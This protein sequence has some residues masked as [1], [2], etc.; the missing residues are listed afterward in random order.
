MSEEKAGPAKNLVLVNL[1]LIALKGFVV[2][3][4]GSLAVA[5]SLFDTCFDLLGAGFA[6]LGMKD[7]AKPADPEHP[8]G[9]GKIEHF[10]SLAQIALITFTAFVIIFEAVKRLV[11]PVMLSIG[12]FDIAIMFFTI[13][14]DVL[15]ARY[16][17]KQSH[18]LGS[19]ALAAAAAN[20]KS[21]ILQNSSALLGL[22]AYSYFGAPWADSAA[23]PSTSYWTSP[24]TSKPCS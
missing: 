15:L 7:A 19:T 4:T 17:Q 23:S 20:Y 13:G 22:V 12:L 2:L 18:N 5:A 16:L 24:P 10:A 14:V 9:H 11:S 21:D 8:Y 1:G 3:M 6:Y